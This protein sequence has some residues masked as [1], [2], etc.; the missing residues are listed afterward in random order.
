MLLVESSTGSKGGFGG[1]SGSPFV[2][3]GEVLPAGEEA[4]VLSALQLQLQLAEVRTK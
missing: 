1:S 2:C 3:V 4:A